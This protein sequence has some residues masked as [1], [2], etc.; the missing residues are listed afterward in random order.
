MSSPALPPVSRRRFVQTLA[1]GAALLATADWRALAAATGATGSAPWFKR[2]LRWGQLNLAEIDA[3][4]LDI[5]WWRKQW[6][7]TA[8]QGV[9]VNAGGIVAYYPTEVPFHR[10]AKY[11]GDRDL[12]GELR[13]AAKEDGLAVFARMDSNRAHEEFYRAHPDWF[14]H[15]AEGQPYKWTDLYIACVNSPYYHEF[16]PAVLHEIATK[17]RPEGFTDN[18]W[19]GPMR[20]QPCYCE[21]C[22]RAFRA[23]SGHEIPRKVDWESSIYRDW[24]MWNYERR[25]QI[26]DTFNRITRDAAGPDC[27]WVGMMAGS[28][29]W[30]SRVFRDDY[31][32]YR[33][34]EL[35]MLD[36]QR[37]FDHE[38]FQHNSATGVRL[39]AVGGWDKIIPE[40]IGFYYITEQ[41]FRLAAKP[42]P[43]VRLW[44]AEAFAGGIQPWWHHVSGE[45]H[46]QRSLHYAEPLWQWHRENEQYLVNRIPAATVGVV[47]SQ[48]NMDFL[49]RDEGGAHVD[50]PADGFLQALVRARIPYVS[51][52]VDDIERVSKELGLRALVLPNLGALSDAQASAIRGFVEA[53]G[54]LFATGLSSAC[55]EWG[56][57]RTDFA[58]ADLFGAHLPAEHPFRTDAA[59]TRWAKEWAQ[60]YLRLSPELRAAG[61]GPKVGTEPPARGERHPVLRDFDGTD[62]VAF[63]GQLAPLALDPDVLVPLTFVPTVPQVPAEAVWMHEPVTNIPALVLN[64]KPNRGRVA[65]LPADLDRRFSRQ[66]IP[67]HGNLLAQLTRWVARDEIPLR[68]EGPGLIDCHLYRQAGR[69]VFHV[70]NLTNANTW[71]TP[72]HELIT[73]GPWEIS[74]HLPSG[75]RGRSAT[76]LVRK[77]SLPC[78]VENDWVRFTL[79]PLADHDV[80][81]IT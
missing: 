35:I 12:F 50:D 55:N 67:D 20:H 23:R 42:E 17:Y 5:P 53:G 46:D 13:A 24:I 71:R 22:Q 15:D 59:R 61:D 38:G 31:E 69:L 10:R 28:Q 39:H 29:N 79:P 2:A 57:A 34:T 56:D 33:R 8:L 73:L 77:T 62:I 45:Q 7:R 65:Y 43:E 58:L 40:S 18:N 81:V 27:I 11:L 75:V 74:I 30:Q 44:T 21:H 47:W 49:G 63:G 78:S 36:H 14:A 60:T 76:S 41:T 70:V 6:K 66:Y 16:L 1:G 72:V 52:H 19:N 48:R 54:G 64:E 68:V 32:V 25:L 26:W 9:V 51:V 4:H 37:R 80:L 3:V